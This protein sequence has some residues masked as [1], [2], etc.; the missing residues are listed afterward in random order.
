M[1][2]DATTAPAKIADHSTYDDPGA[3]RGVRVVGVVVSVMA[4]ISLCVCCSAQTE[5]G[6]N[7]HDDH[8]KTND[9]DDA[10][11]DFLHKCDGLW[12][13]VAPFRSNL[14]GQCRLESLSP[15]LSEA[16]ASLSPTPF[17]SGEGALEKRPDWAAFLSKRIPG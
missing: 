13:G 3:L 1:I 14:R 12:I 5:K 2:A 11:H 16:R 9:V 17:D 6:K 4:R 7:G 10:V 15:G 8:D